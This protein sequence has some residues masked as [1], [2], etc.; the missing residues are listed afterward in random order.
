MALSRDTDGGLGK[1]DDLLNRPHMRTQARFHRA[2]VTRNSDARGKVSA[3]AY[4]SKGFIGVRRK[5][6]LE[7]LIFTL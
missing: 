4:T 2:E 3:L 6:P 7:Q 5:I 1:I